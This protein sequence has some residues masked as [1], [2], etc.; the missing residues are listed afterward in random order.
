MLG[1][2]VGREHLGDSVSFRFRREDE[3]R[4]RELTALEQECCA[5]WRF[6]IEPDGAEVVMGVGV[7]SPRF[8]PFVDRFYDLAT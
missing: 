1:R 5:F 4:L 2:A 7:V 6:N 3:A 8:A